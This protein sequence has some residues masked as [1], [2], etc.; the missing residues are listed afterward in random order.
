MWGKVYLELV[1]VY[2]IQA[3]ILRPGNSSDTTSQERWWVLC[4]VV[5]SHPGWI[6]LCTEITSNEVWYIKKKPNSDLNLSFKI[7]EHIAENKPWVSDFCKMMYSNICGIHFLNYIEEQV[8]YT[9]KKINSFWLCV[10]ASRW[11]EKE[12]L[13]NSLGHVTELFPAQGY[14]D[15]VDLSFLR[16]P[17]KF[18]R[19]AVMNGQ[20]CSL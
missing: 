5:T 2:W 18:H 9:E 7:Q 1:D 8:E 12:K 10:C 15:A 3:L 11:W 6:S 14:L 17:T 13:R 19:P 16:V 4:L 20:V